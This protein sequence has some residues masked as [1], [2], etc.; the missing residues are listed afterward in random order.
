MGPL[1]T[2][3]EI[4]KRENVDIFSQVGENIFIPVFL[5]TSLTLHLLGAWWHTAFVTFYSATRIVS[6]NNDF[7]YRFSSEPRWCSILRILHLSAISALVH[8][9][10]YSSK[11]PQI[12]IYDED[13]LVPQC[14]QER[15]F[16]KMITISKGSNHIKMKPI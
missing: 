9:P 6:N 8:I 11:M 13:R 5:A 10:R 15:I 16:S 2:L 3:T 12:Q 4:K 7:F 1:G 14:S